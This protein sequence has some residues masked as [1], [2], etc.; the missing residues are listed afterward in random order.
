MTLTK[1]VD[2][3]TCDTVSDA[4]QVHLCDSTNSEHQ[5]TYRCN[6]AHW[7]IGAV[8]TPA[9]VGCSTG[10]FFVDALEVTTGKYKRLYE[11]PPARGQPIG[12]IAGVNGCSINPVDSILYC[13]VSMGTGT[14]YL[15]RVDAAS[16]V[17]VGSCLCQADLRRVAA[18]TSSASPLW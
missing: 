10:V 11:I 5:S 7:A 15:A 8:S 17:I 3:I 4:I 18:T 6:P 1:A 12:E 16:V 13:F 2:P 9:C 14:L